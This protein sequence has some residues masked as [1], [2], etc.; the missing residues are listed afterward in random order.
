MRRSNSV[1]ARNAAGW[2][3]ESRVNTTRRSV[4]TTSN[5]AEKETCKSESWRETAPF[6]T[7]HQKFLSWGNISP[8]HAHPNAPTQ[9]WALKIH[10]GDFWHENVA[11]NEGVTQGA[12]RRMYNSTKG[13][14]PW[15][16][17]TRNS[18]MLPVVFTPKQFGSC[19]I[20]NYSMSHVARASHRG[21]STIRTWFANFTFRAG[22][23]KSGLASCS[24]SLSFCRYSNAVQQYLQIVC[25]FL[26]WTQF[27]TL[28]K[29][30]APFNQRICNLIE[31]VRFKIATKS[32]A[33]IIDVHLSCSS[34]T[35]TLFVQIYATSTNNLLDHA[36][37][38]FLHSSPFSFRD[39]EGATMQPLLLSKQLI[40]NVPVLC[41]RTWKRYCL[42]ERARSTDEYIKTETYPGSPST[43]NPRAFPA[44]ALCTRGQCT[45]VQAGPVPLNTRSTHAF[46]ELVICIQF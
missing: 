37:E 39:R 17:S 22:Q 34:E 21:K 28:D 6:F 26:A 44:H 1:T 45:S 19:G 15:S 23:W 12:D 29:R 43:C 30:W 7:R 5:N 31:H 4:E 8:R 40:Y 20:G 32:P 16:M 36:H 27:S 3:V 42:N 9:S 13:N 2:C 41:M 25:T 24:S 18:R 38:E 11:P 14:A 35:F 33:D 10:R 46:S